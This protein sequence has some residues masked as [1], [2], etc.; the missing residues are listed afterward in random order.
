MGFWCEL[1][2]I[3]EGLV[4]KNLPEPASNVVPFFNTILLF[5]KKVPSPSCEFGVKRELQQDRWVNSS[6]SPLIFVLVH[7]LVSLS[8]LN[9]NMMSTLCNYKSNYELFGLPLLQ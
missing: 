2:A 1:G 6:Q 7:G 4:G 8:L 9:R 5:V 3:T